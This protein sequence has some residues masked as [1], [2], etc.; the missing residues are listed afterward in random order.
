MIKRERRFKFLSAPRRGEKSRKANEKQNK[1]KS[2]VF[3]AGDAKTYPDGLS[4]PGTYF[5]NIIKVLHVF[6]LLLV[7]PIIF[8][9]FSSSSLARALS[10]RD[11]FFF[12]SPVS[13]LPRAGTR[14]DN[15]HEEYIKKKV[16]TPLTKDK[17]KFFFFFLLLIG[18][19][20]GLFFWFWFITRFK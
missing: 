4:P 9:F 11:L 17:L 18:L 2:R 12:S 19:F 10:H 3:W 16:Q 1:T 15:G 14:I 20:F 13:G 8:F 6:S 5:W 7:N